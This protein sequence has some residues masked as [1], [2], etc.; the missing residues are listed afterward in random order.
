[1]VEERQK[2]INLEAG[3]GVGKLV[4]IKGKISSETE[5]LSMTSDDNTMTPTFDNFGKTET[6][7]KSTQEYGHIRSYW[8]QNNF[9]YASLFLKYALMMMNMIT[10]TIQRSMINQTKTSMTMK[11]LMMTKMIWTLNPNIKKL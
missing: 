8:F 3:L 6:V 11:R 9:N 10:L 5:D 7:S 1:M 2:R 4:D